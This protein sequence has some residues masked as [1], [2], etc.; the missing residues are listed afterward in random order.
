[1]IAHGQCAQIRQIERF[2]DDVEVE[3]TFGPLARHGQAGAVD[4]N[5]CSGLD[6]RSK[7]PQPDSQA[8]EVRLLFYTD[9]GAI[10]L[11]D[12]RE[13]TTMLIQKSP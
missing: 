4:G 12:S 2:L 13:H 3:H 7:L 5:G 10:A 6:T 1:M 9:D 8:F 11:D